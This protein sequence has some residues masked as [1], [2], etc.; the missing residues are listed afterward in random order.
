MKL[1]LVY[2]ALALM[3]AQKLLKSLQIVQLLACNQ[4]PDTPKAVRLIAPG[5]GNK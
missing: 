5:V 2:V 1:L 3:R 4:H